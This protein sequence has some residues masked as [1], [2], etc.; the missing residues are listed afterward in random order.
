M[1][2]KTQ[3]HSNAKYLFLGILTNNNI[4]HGLIL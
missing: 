3:A 1:R 4:I 2:G